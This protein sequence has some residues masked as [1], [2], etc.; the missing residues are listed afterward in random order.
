MYRQSAMAIKKVNQSLRVGGPATAQAAWVGDL[1]E[2]C[3]AQN[4]PIDFASTH[5]YPDD[6]QKRVFGDGVHYPI[7][8]VMQRALTMVK[9]QIKASKFPN[10]PLYLTEWSSQNPAFIANTIKS[11]AGLAEM[12]AYWTFDS[13]YEELGIPKSFLNKSFGLIGMRGIPR[14]S[15]HTFTLLHRLGD[16]QLA[17]DEAPVLATRRK[18]GSLA[19]LIWNLLPQDPKHRTSMGDPLVQT[20]VQFATQGEAKEFTLQLEGWH[21]RGS[22]KLSRVDR[23]HGDLG[24]AYQKIGAPEYP[25][26]PQI[27][28]LKLMSALREPEIVHLDHQGQITLSVPPNG[29]A[30]LELE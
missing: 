30:L 21:K 29:V 22:V 19:I 14:P 25:T 11:C 2:F 5:V 12:M 7:E 20:D 17:A 3:A 13:V 18:D 6:P 15:F 4:V 9:Q 27:A 8:E 16:V 28:E 26:M 10:L 23:E 24:R 1:L